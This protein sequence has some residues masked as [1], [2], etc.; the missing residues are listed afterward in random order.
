M[1]QA[2]FG[3]GNFG[4][5]EYFNDDLPLQL[6]DL[7]DMELF[8]KLMDA[9]NFQNMSSIRDEVACIFNS[10][11]KPWNGINQD[12]CLKMLDDKIGIAA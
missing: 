9:K 10:I 12:N 2:R 11:L 7:L 5:P 3:E 8:S 4:D 6:S 1:I